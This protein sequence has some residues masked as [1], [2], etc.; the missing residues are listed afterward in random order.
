MKSFSIKKSLFISAP[1]I[2]LFDAL[3]NP[4][5]II[6]YYPLKEVISDWQVGSDILLKGN[7]NGEEFTD[8]G[9]IDI[10]TPNQ[11]FQ[12]TYWSDNHGTNRTP[13]NQLTICYT[14]DEVDNGTNLQ[15]EHK[16]LNSEK[17]YSEMLNIWDLLLSSLK[18]F[19]EKGKE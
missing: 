17:M 2:L 11:K 5:K 1:P 15:L 7:N 6:Q 16:N 9:T 12:Y 14:L 19:V 18:N 4:E 8:Y 3:T 10:L 13:E